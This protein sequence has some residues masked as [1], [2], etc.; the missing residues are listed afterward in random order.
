MT[1]RAS[2]TFAFALLALF[3]VS[4]CDGG[5]APPNPDASVMDASAGA[6]LG[7]SCTAAAGCE[8]GYLRL[9]IIDPGDRGL[10][11]RTT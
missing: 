9:P 4:G 6:P 5:G 2:H 3:A 11:S 8:S 1:L 10:K 7:A